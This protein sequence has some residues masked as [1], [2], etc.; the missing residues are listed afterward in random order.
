MFII[1]MYKKNVFLSIRFY[2]LKGG[3][4]KPK[5]RMQRDLRQRNFLSLCFQLFMG[6][7]RLYI[8]KIVMR[9]GWVAFVWNVNELHHG[10]STLKP[11]VSVT[12]I[13]HGTIVELNK[14]EK[15]LH[16]KRKINK[17]FIRFFLLACCF[18]P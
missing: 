16:A 6:L 14:Y 12:S 18:F 8:N 5:E 2:E 10:R 17:N 3:K 4:A 9:R 1:S 7:M 11:F 13:T 15:Y